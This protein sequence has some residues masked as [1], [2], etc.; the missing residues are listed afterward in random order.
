MVDNA[1]DKFKSFEKSVRFIED[2]ASEPSDELF[3]RDAPLSGHRKHVSVL[4]QELSSNSADLKRLSAQHTSDNYLHD[5]A[6]TA[7]ALHNTAPKQRASADTKDRQKLLADKAIVETQF[8]EF[9]TVMKVSTDCI[10]VSLDD[11]VQ[12]A[13]GPER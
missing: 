6:C 8:C 9:R 12:R 13:N 5:C 11:T 7:L 2:K 4:K 10:Q 1:D 3:E